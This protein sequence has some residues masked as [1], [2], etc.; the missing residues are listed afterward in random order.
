MPNMSESPLIV[1]LDVDSQ[2]SAIELAKRLDPAISKLKIGKELFTSCGPSVVEAVQN[3]GFKVFLDLKFHDI[4]NTT[5][6][7]V[8]AAANLGVWMVNVHASGGLEMMQRCRE[9]L[10]ASSHK[11]LLIAV[12]VLT[13]MDKT[14]LAGIGLQ[15]EPVEQVIR[16]ALLAKQAELDGVVSSAQEVPLIKKECGQNFLTVTPGIRPEQSASNDQKRTMTPREAIANG[17]DFLVIGRPI[18]QADNPAEAARKIYNDIIK[19]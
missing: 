8:R 19:G 3:L 16:L 1:A 14:G 9:V 13:S 15:G 5:A 11:P 2:A 10:E 12:T 4:P 7:A 17:S 6:Q 18:T